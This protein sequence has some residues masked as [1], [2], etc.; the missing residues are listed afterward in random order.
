MRYAPAGSANNMSADGVIVL[1]LQ[2]C[3]QVQALRVEAPCSQPLANKDLFLD[4]NGKDATSVEHP[5]WGA[6]K[7]AE[8]RSVT[9]AFAHVV[10]FGRDD[11]AETRVRKGLLSLSVRS[12]GLSGPCDNARSKTM[13]SHKIATAMEVPG[14]SANTRVARV[15]DVQGPLPRFVWSAETDIVKITCNR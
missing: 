5:L 13:R 1:V 4:H 12:N 8:L 10:D 14:V 7:A 15:G 11:R 3:Q 2:V 6:V 9:S